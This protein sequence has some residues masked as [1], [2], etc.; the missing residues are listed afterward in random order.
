MYKAIREALKQSPII[1]LLMGLLHKA[2]F[3]ST[4]AGANA[5]VKLM[6]CLGLPRDC[7]NNY[8]IILWLIFVL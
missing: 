3:Y 4:S 5:F 1:C 8:P 7:K 2:F 6:V